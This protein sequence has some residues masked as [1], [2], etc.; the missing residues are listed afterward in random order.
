VFNYNFLVFAA[1]TNVDASEQKSYKMT[2]KSISK[3]ELTA[4]EGPYMGQKPPG[5]IPEVFAPVIVS[6]NGR[7]E[8]AISFSPDLDEMYFAA[9]NK[10]EE[11]VIYFSKLDSN[12]WTPIEKVS[13]TKGKKDQ[14]IHPFVSPDGKRIYFTA[15]SSDMSDTG[16]WYVNRLEHSW[17]N[18]V[19]LDL[20][21]NDDL[22]FFP[23]QANNKDLYYFNLSKMKTYFAAYNNGG[24]P[25]AK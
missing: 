6:L 5:L 24:F 17:S 2:S 13:F 25:E 23:N 11:T 14:E 15:L 3:H 1:S 12:K 20:P 4:L 8:G 9:H 18:A 10:N 19:K 21:T 16:I 22:V 7:Y